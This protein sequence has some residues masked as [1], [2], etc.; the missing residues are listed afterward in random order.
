MTRRAMLR[1]PKLVIAGVILVVL[2]L[3]SIVGSL[4]QSSRNS[5]RAPYAGTYV[6]RSLDQ[7]LELGKDGTWKM[8][9][10]T[11]ARSRDNVAKSE[12]SPGGA[13]INS[14]WEVVS[15]HEACTDCANPP[16]FKHFSGDRAIFVPTHWAKMRGGSVLSYW[17]DYYGIVKKGHVLRDEAG[18]RWS[19]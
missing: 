13:I 10:G 5:D 15:A 16:H 12:C 6:S 19:R 17:G 1:H 18:H 14:C 11:G 4:I 9:F 3:I 2:L 7:R 8:Y